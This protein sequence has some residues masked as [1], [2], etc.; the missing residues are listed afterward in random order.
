MEE[1]QG[2][3]ELEEPELEEISEVSDQLDNGDVIL[4]YKRNGKWDCAVC[5]WHE[6]DL[7][8]AETGEVFREEKLEDWDIMP[9][10][11]T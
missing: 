3:Y 2:G 9:I 6:S 4:D 8:D 5:K 7:I 11:H 10:F 1:Y